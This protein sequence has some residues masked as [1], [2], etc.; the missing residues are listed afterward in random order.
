VPR[1]E[2]NGPRVLLSLIDAEPL[3]FDRIAISDPP[4][5]CVRDPASIRSPLPPG[6]RAIVHRAVRQRSHESQMARLRVDN[7]WESGCDVGLGTDHRLLPEVLGPKT[8]VAGAVEL[9]L[10][11]GMKPLTVLKQTC[12]DPGDVR[13]VLAAEPER[14]AHA[15][16]SLRG[17]SLGRSGTGV[18]DC[19]QRQNAAGD[20]R[21]LL[22]RSHLELLL[23][24][25]R[26]VADT[27]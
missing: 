24:I 8:T 17:G 22:I 21:R 5:P 26:L 7:R 18:R 13:N 15:C 6:T 19:H 11:S 27:W 9:S 16:G 20:N 2:P 25:G 10:A 3:L 23:L 4:A 12:F 1:N 14:I